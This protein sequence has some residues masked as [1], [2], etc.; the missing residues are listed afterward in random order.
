MTK[1]VFYLLLLVSFI[2]LSCKQSAQNQDYISDST[3]NANQLAQNPNLKLQIYYF[4]ATHRCK[5]CN[6]IENNVKKV[7]DD[8]YKE[9]MAKGIINLKVLCVDD[10]AN[11]ALAEKY[12]AA[13]ASL[14]LVKIENG[15]EKDNDLTDFAFSYSNVEP[16][17]F[18]KGMKDTVQSI[19]Q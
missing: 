16:D 18:L 12:E 4:H 11:K 2:V 13:G 8:N 10:E 14:H 9:Q 5:T 17:L 19:I 3:A 7:L 6:S 1:S 15:V